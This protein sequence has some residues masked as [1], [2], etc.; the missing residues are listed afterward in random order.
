MSARGIAM[1]ALLLL[2]SGGFAGAEHFLGKDTEAVAQG[3]L[4]TVASGGVRIS[5]QATGK[6][7]QKSV[8]FNSAKDRLSYAVGV[9]WAAGL[10][11]QRMD[12]DVNL[13]VRGLQDAFAGDDTKLLMTAKEL[14]TTLKD[15]RTE[16]ARGVAHAKQMLAE[17]N[18][19]AGAVFVAQNVKKNGV[20]T[21]PSGLQY[22]VLKIGGGK[23]P[24]LE[25]V[26]ECHY[27]GT[28]LDGTEF[29]SSYK[30]K[31][32]TFPLKRAIAGW[33]EA[34]QLMPVGSKWQLFVPPQLAYGA[35][36]AGD[37]IGPNATTIFEVELI[38]VKEKSRSANGSGEDN[39]QT[40]AARQGV[41]P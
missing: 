12:V 23:R 17:K 4:A 8:Q 24:T 19:Q 26:V 1:L 15:Y 7:P 29:D 5:Q 36:G 18:G 16:Q 41:R 3:T 11:W 20:V 38:S 2:L 21:L 34:L 32:A 6:Q 22:K 25:D 14:A 10:K 40:V 27:R 37:T 31:P 28:L 39:S 13:V 33:R 9:E 35:R 30:A